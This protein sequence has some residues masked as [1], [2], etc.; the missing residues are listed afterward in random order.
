MRDARSPPCATIREMGFL[1]NVFRRDG[2]SKS[3]SNPTHDWPEA[4]GECPQ[5]SFDRQALES[6]GSRLRFGDGLEAARLF[7]RPDTFESGEASFTL[8]YKRWALS[9]G[10]EFGKFAHATYGI[11]ES[12]RDRDIAGAPRAEPRGPDG[13]SLTARTTKSDLLGRF[14]QPGTVQDL[15]GEIVLYYEYGPLIS[16][17]QLDEDERLTGWDVYV[18]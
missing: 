14:G 17:F 10:F 3:D 8:T 5:V 13:L 12:I 15:E 16:E 4:A 9:L 11:G 18:N 2:R 7:G 6:F 1:S